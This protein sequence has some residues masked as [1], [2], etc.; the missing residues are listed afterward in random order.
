MEK[1]SISFITEYTNGDGILTK[2]YA[3]ILE[4]CDDTLHILSQAY[5]PN[6]ISVYIMGIV[7]REHNITIQCNKTK[8]DRSTLYISSNSPYPGETK[9]LNYYYNF[10]RELDSEGMVDWIIAKLMQLSTEYKA[11]VDAN[12][13]MANSLLKGND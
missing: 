7:D 1:K 4:L 8:D 13:D 5:R 11:V 9:P 2:S 10:F 3:D 6:V 12:E